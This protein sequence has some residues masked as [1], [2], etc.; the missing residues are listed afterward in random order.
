MSETFTLRAAVGAR[1]LATVLIG[2]LACAA[3]VGAAQSRSDAAKDYPNRPIRLIVQFLPGTTTDIVARFVGAKLSEA[4][5]QQ[6]VI[7][8][9][10]GAGGTLGTELAARAVPDGHTML[11][12]SNSFRFGCQRQ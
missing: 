2:C 5:G 11:Y 1:G 12:T 3:D 4:W 9:R 10:P 6:V 7:D 8:N